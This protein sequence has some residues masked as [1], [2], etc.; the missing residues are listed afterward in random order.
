MRIFK[1][2]KEKAYDQQ[3]EKYMMALLT[4]KLRL[5]E[6][7]LWLLRDPGR[8]SSLYLTAFRIDR[9]TSEEQYRKDIDFL[10][11]EI[12]YAQIRGEDILAEIL[13]QVQKNATLGLEFF[14]KLE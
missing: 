2:L 9:G 10:N 4:C 7:P 11:M 13:T 6:V 14:K 8:C 12:I 1:A 3:A 5:K